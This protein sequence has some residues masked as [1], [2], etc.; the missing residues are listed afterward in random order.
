MYPSIF[1]QSLLLSIPLIS[2]TRA[3]SVYDSV[4][5]PT[6]RAEFALSTL[7][8]WYN[9]GTGLWD[10]AG[11]WNSANVMT[12][13]ANLAKS[14]PKNAQLQNL[15]TR[16]FAN[17]LLQAPAKNPQPG[18]EN[19]AKRKRDV[20]PGNGTFTLLLNETGTESGYSKS[21]NPDTSEPQTT[22]PAD[23]DAEDGQYVDIQRLPSFASESKD[24]A[25]QAALATAPNPEDWLDG[26]YDDDLWWA[27]AWIGA[28]DVTQNIQY[29][30]LAE[31]IFGQVTKA[32]PTRCGNG[33]IFWS[34]KKDYMNAIANE[35]F[36]S[37]AAHLANRAQNKDTYIEWAELTLNWF[38]N[39][40]MINEQ[41]TI[42]DG[43]TEGCENNGYTTWSYNQG[44]IL[45]GLVELNKALPNDTYLPLASKIAKAGIAELS[46]NEGVIHDGCEPG[47]GGDGSQFKGIFMRNLQLLHQV[48]PDDTF[49]DS[50]RA[51]AN[52]V[53]ANN[54]DEGQ[55][56]TL[57]I[58]WAGPFVSPAN[59]STHSSAMD[60]LVAAIAL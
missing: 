44:V 17:T 3:Q 13:I 8:I 27:L 49:A 40:G 38:L 47:C 7:Q 41:G 34:W 11:W 32:W 37:T 21:L 55:G 9:A 15:A 28:Y 60:A 31:G 52:S 10:T 43:L 12:M 45:G 25:T 57:S 14:D 24:A 16:V 6:K 22:F 20:D 56:N 1:I 39:S 19:E 58:N 42:N 35:L 30:Q 18:V 50:I 33:G 48:A 54:R 36:F 46:D 23:W 5:D 53:W 51:N 2:S 29:L 59:A 4:T 26:F